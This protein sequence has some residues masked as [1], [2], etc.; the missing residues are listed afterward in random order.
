MM[1]NYG[2]L[3]F[4]SN[5]DAEIQLSHTHDLNMR[6]SYE[7]F[8]LS[9]LESGHSWNGTIPADTPIM[10]QWSFSFLMIHEENWNLFIGLG[11]LFMLAAG[12]ITVSYTHL[13]L[14]TI[15]LV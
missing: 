5:D 8:E 2:T 13:T 11:G 6:L 10:I 3:Y 7:G 9:I 12:L 15:L 14:P 1:Q 4:Y